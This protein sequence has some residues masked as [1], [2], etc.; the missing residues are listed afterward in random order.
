MQGLLW[1]ASEEDVAIVRND[2]MD[3]V[4]LAQKGG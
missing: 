2:E 1:L 4:L 3:F